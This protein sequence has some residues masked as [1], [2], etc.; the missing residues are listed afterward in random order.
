M[1]WG[2][3][4]DGV[5]ARC[6][7]WERRRAPVSRP[8][9]SDR[10]GRGRWGADIPAPLIPR[11]HGRQGKASCL[12]TLRW[13]GCSSCCPRGG[14]EAAPAA[15]VAASPPT[16]PPTPR[17]ARVPP[18]YYDHPLEYRRS[19]VGAASVDHLCKALIMENTRAHPSVDGW[20]DPRNSKY[21]LVGSRLIF[22]PRA[23]RVRDLPACLFRQLHCPACLP[24]CVRCQP[25]ALCFRCSRNRGQATTLRL[26]RRPSL[27]V[28]FSSP[29]PPPAPPAGERVC[30]WSCSTPRSSPQTSSGTTCTA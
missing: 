29:A 20:S 7:V 4:R 28:P 23:A 9:H 13:L 25:K 22:P 26:A 19:C 18:D 1:I 6:T 30:R 12:G 24:A 5:C 11:P 27:P 10:G 2:G 17:F 16:H 21:Y 14:P 3:M 15:A 8:R